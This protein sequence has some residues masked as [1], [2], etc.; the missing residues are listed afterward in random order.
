VTIPFLRSGGF[1]SIPTQNAT[2]NSSICSGERSQTFEFFAISGGTS[3]SPG[4]GFGDPAE[5]A[6]GL[7]DVTGAGSGIAGAADS[8]TAGE[9]DADDATEVAVFAVVDPQALS[10][11]RSATAMASVPAVFNMVA[12]FPIRK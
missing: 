5:G 4:D 9:A 10:G 6:A 8:S 11:R 7:S 2:R 1:P 12:P 3:V